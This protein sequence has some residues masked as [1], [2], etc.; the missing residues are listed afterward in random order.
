MDTI[1]GLLLIFFELFP[2]W[3]LLS[4]LR[5]GRGGKVPR[6]RP[7]ASGVRGGGEARQVLG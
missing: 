4:I 7:S 2:F 3:L 1:G 5:P 6:A